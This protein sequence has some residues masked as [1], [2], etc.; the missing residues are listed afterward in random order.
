M[1]QHSTSAQTV[2]D[3]P[4]GEGRLSTS[5]WGW[6]V[7]HTKPRQ[8][9]IARENLERQ[10]FEVYLPLWRVEKIRRGRA[11]WVE[12]PLFPRY[13]FIRLDTSQQGR[14]WSPIRSTL[15]VSTLVRFGTQPARMADDWVTL[16]RERQQLLA[17]KALFE[18]GDRVVIVDG[19][20]A[21]IEAIFQTADA[22]RRSL[23][24]LE[25]LSKPTAMKID[26]GQLR[27][28]EAGPLPN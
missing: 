10:G 8:E 17:E 15:G 13:L 19:P 14:S 22:E 24:L 5:V 21:G 26:T 18:P 2:G 6:Y 27:R 11:Q 1:S 9:L 4:A 12:E 28:L 25:I 3:A 16:L 7:V 23:I 20:F